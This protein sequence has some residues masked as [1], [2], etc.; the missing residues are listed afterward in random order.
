LDSFGGAR[1]IG[2]INERII[3]PTSSIMRTLAVPQNAMAEDGV[4]KLIYLE[5]GLINSKSEKV[6]PSDSFML[7]CGGYSQEGFRFA[8][9]GVHDGFVSAIRNNSELRGKFHEQKN[10]INSKQTWA[11]IALFLA[12]F[13][14]FFGIWAFISILI[15]LFRFVRYGRKP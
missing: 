5:K 4:C 3:F 1:L 2:G 13:I 9:Q 7:I 11:A 14:I 8:I 12:P 10:L 15:G 6:A